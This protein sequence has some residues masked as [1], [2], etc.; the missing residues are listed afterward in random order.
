MI[1]RDGSRSE[2][3]R[4]AAGFL[5]VIDLAIK[6]LARQQTWTCVCSL[7]AGRLTLGKSCGPIRQAAP[8]RLR[9]SRHA[10]PDPLRASPIGGESGRVDGSG[11]SEV[12]ASTEVGEF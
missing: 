10:V 6:G 11:G 1:R 5:A 7:R 4:L 8:H 3:V 9:H 12:Y 2:Q